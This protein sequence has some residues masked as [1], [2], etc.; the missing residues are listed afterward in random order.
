M[1]DSMRS[2]VANRLNIKANFILGFPGET[3]RQVLETYVFIARMAAAGIHDLSVFPFSPYPG[4]ELFADLQKRGRLKLDDPYFYSL[5]QYT[6]PGITNSYCDNISHRMLFLL[7]LL[8][9]LLFYAIGY[10]CKPQR[11]FRT[12]WNILRDR[13][14]SKLETSVQRV[15]RK[16]SQRRAASRSAA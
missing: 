15:L 13:P 3:Y 6:D 4:S 11:F 8:G 1:L 16:R 2:A 12:A 7:T 5:S 10:A 9:M 14:E